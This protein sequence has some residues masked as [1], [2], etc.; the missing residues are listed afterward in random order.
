MKGQ[1]EVKGG[2]SRRRRRNT[3]WEKGEKKELKCRGTKGNIGEDVAKK[4]EEGKEKMETGEEAVCSSQRKEGRKE[5]RKEMKL[6]EGMK[7][8]NLQKGKKG[9]RKLERRGGR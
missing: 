4:K 6:E 5:T 8:S 2:S 7:R 3:V 9:E 1:K